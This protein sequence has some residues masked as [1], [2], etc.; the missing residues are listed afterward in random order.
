V[1]LFPSPLR[2]EGEGE[3]VKGRDR[4]YPAVSAAGRFIDNLRGFK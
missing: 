1:S 3:G 2:G 4:R